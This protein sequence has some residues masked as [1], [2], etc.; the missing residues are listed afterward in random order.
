M[1]T[2]KSSTTT[3]KSSQNNSVKTPKGEQWNLLSSMLNVVLAEMQVLSKSK[4]NDALNEFKVKGINKIL[5]KIKDLLSDEPTI[6]FLEILDEETMP[7]NSDAVLMLVQF[8][9]AMIQFKAKHHKE[10]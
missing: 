4:P 3:I 1:A 9:S 7:K 5:S 2:F 8:K 6:E 10:L